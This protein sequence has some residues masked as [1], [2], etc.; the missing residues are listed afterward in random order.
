MQASTPFRD[1]LVDDAFEFI[2]RRTLDMLTKLEHTLLAP[3]SSA[4]WA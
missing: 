4:G 3:G 2:G 1:V